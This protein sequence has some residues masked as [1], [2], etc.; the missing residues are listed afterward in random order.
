MVLVILANFNWDR[1]IY[2]ATSIGRDNYMG[3][4]DYFRMEGFAY[5]L[6]PY[7]TKPLSDGE[8]GEVNTD[9]L[10]DNVMHKF[11]WGN[12]ADPRFN[13][14]HYVERTV[15]VMD[16][17]G[18]FHR[19]AEALIAENKLDSAEQVLDK[20]IEVLPDRQIAFDY[21]IIPI[22]DDYYKINKVEKANK[23]LKQLFTNYNQQ[24]TYLQQFKGKDAK[25]VNRDMQIGLY[26]IQQL[27]FMADKYKQ[28]DIKKML[29]PVLQANISSLQ[30]GQ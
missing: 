24:I 6:M 27:Y 25:L 20:C 1:P 26:V 10:Y 29:E 3:L 12:I 18:T 5:R 11:K 22:I 16:I 15:G 14:D 23:I 4:T 13:V 8:M 19:L 28:E 17:R 7:K 2:F 9:I 21:G 30:L